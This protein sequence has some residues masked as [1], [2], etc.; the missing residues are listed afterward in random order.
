EQIAIGPQLNAAL[1]SRGGELGLLLDLTDSYDND[2]ADGAARALTQLGGCIDR[3]ALNQCLTESMA[4]VRS[5]A[6]EAA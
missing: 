4:W 1:L 6:S 3:E 2:D 5:L